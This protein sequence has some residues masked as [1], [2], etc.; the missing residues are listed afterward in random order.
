MGA[1]GERHDQLI[2]TG[3]AVACVVAAVMEG[4][5]VVTGLVPT[6]WFAPDIGGAEHLEVLAFLIVPTVLI[7]CA[8]AMTRYWLA[9]VV[10]LAVASCAFSY[11][12]AVSVLYLATAPRSAPAH[13]AAALALTV[14]L[15]AAVRATAPSERAFS[16]VAGVVCITFGAVGTALWVPLVVESGAATTDAITIVAP[17][18]VLVVCGIGMLI[19]AGRVFAVVGAVVTAVGAVVDAVT[20]SVLVAAVLQL[21]P[22]TVLL[23]TAS[24][25]GRAKRLPPGPSAA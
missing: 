16:T 9:A 22:L 7:L 23:V 10:A 4:V 18:P 19:S 3:A 15:T 5:L 25:H 13:A 2:V 20:V 8:D 21:V 24:I 14:A 1:P 11:W 17:W 6:P 12:L